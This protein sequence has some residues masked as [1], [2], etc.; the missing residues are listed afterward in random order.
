[1]ENQIL[2]KNCPYLKPIWPV[3]IIL[4]RLLLHEAIH[5]SQG[6]Y[7]NTVRVRSKIQGSGSGFFI[8]NLEEEVTHTGRLRKKF[9]SLLRASRMLLFAAMSYDSSNMVESPTLNSD[10]SNPKN[11]R[12][13]LFER[14]SSISES[15]KGMYK[16]MCLQVSNAHN[17]TFRSSCGAIELNESDC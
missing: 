9:S 1:M 12:N 7:R 8:Y 15:L 10:P 6:I 13:E 14:R 2:A 4:F 5:G 17:V 3:N 16:L 11:M